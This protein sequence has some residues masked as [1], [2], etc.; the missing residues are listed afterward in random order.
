[1]L[2]LLEPTAGRVLFDG[3]DLADAFAPRSARAAPPD[4]A[5]F[6]GSL[7]VAQPAHARALD[8]RRG[9]R[10]SSSSRAA[11]RKSERI[12]ELLEMVG[13][14]ADALD[15]LPA[16]I[17]RRPA[18]ADRNRARAGREPAL[19]GAR[20]AGLR[21]RRLDPGADHQPA[22]GPA[23]AAAADLPFHRARSA[24]GRAHQPAR[25]RSC[26]WAKSWSWPTATKSTPTRAIPTRARCSRR[27][28]R[29]DAA[30]PAERI[31]L[32]GEVPSPLN[33]P[34]GC[35]F[36]PRCPYAKDICRTVEPPL[37]TGRGGHAVACHVFPAP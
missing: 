3:R 23:G 33:P 28:R 8:R 13:M 17:L 22:A 26:T 19:P 16:R 25:R 27:F 10:N 2:K 30:A 7:R 31:K 11:A 20:R 34:P 6:P 21:A 35:S 29:C 24:G 37:E 12:V 5:R 4:A 14:G 1:M 9:N 36:H 32:P 15:A 18:P